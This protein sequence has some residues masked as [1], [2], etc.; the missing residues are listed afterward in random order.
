MSVGTCASDSV[1]ISLDGML[2]LIHL[3][4]CCGGLSRGPFAFGEEWRTWD[5]SS[6][7]SVLGQL[8]DWFCCV[9]DLDVT[10][11]MPSGTTWRLRRFRFPTRVVG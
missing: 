11:N 8:P 1:S 3:V 6:F 9:P 2:C 7:R 4:G 10:D 5:G